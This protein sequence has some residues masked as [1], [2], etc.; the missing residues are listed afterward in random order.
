[1]EPEVLGDDGVNANGLFGD[2]GWMIRN[3]VVLAVILSVVDKY[4]SILR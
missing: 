4:N 2:A 1:M 3:H